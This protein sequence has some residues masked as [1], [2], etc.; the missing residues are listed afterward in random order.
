MIYNSNFNF[1]QPNEEKKVEETL[2]REIHGKWETKLILLC[3]YKCGRNGWICLMIEPWPLN[4]ILFARKIKW[5][6]I[7]L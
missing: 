4:L 6:D 1:T 5:Q 2:N 7:K 3:V